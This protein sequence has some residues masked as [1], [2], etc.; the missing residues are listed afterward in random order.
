MIMYYYK[1]ANTNIN[2]NKNTSWKHLIHGM[3]VLLKDAI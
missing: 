3:V 1:I 2:N